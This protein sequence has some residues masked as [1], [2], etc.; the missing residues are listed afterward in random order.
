MTELAA[1][2]AL[3][4]AIDEVDGYVSGVLGMADGRLGGDDVIDRGGWFQQR[5]RDAGRRLGMGESR[6]ASGYAGAYGPEQLRKASRATDDVLTAVSRLRRSNDQRVFD[7]LAQLDRLAL[8]HLG[9]E[10]TEVSPRSPEL[11]EIHHRLTR[12]RSAA[13]ETTTK[14]TL[15][16]QG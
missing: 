8:D 14:L 13:L 4:D 3:V 5:L 6:V 7:L 11:T 2:G 16:R 10:L 12:A 15:G 9:H 1:L